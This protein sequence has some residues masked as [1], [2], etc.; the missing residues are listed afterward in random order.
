MT[1]NSS[2]VIDWLLRS[3]VYSACLTKKKKWWK[4]VFMSL[5]NLIVVVDW[6]KKNV[7]SYKIPIG[8]LYLTGLLLESSNHQTHKSTTISVYQQ[9]WRSSKGRCSSE[10]WWLPTYCVSLKNRKCNSWIVLQIIIKL[11][12]LLSTLLNA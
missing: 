7:V 12:P 9:I 2:F 4:N 10:Q 8:I 5:I 11:V 3:G 1:K 6:V